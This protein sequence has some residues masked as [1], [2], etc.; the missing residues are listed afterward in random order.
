[1]ALFL[2]TALI[3]FYFFHTGNFPFSSVH[4]ATAGE[5]LVHRATSRCTLAPTPA[6]VA[7]KA[8]VPVNYSHLRARVCV[9]MFFFRIDLN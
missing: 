6:T 5:G 1:M 3:S 8:E 2:E 9:R 7:A 4:L